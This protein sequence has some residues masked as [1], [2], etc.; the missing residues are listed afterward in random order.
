MSSPTYPIVGIPIQ[1]GQPLPLRQEITA[2]QND[3]DNRYQ[4]SLFLR[5]LTNFKA[6]AVED[7][8]GY[9]QIAVFQQLL[10]ENMLE[11]ISKWP[12]NDR[13][14]ETWRAAASQFRLPYWDWAQKQVYTGDYGLPQICT[15][16]TWNIVKPG[17][18]GA[19]EPFDNPLTGFINPKKDSLGQSVPMGDK[20]MGPNAIGDDQDNSTEPPTKLPNATG[21]SYFTS[22]QK[23]ET[24]VGFTGLGL[25]HMSDVPVAAFDPIFWLHH[26]NIDRLCAMWQA[27]NWDKWF[28]SP[29]GKDPKPSQS[30]PPFHYNTQ[31]GS[32]TSDRGRDWRLSNYQYDDLKDMPPGKPTPVFQ[33]SLSQHI[34]NLY[35]STSSI[36]AGT[37]YTLEND[38]FN[39]YIINVVYDRYALKGRAYS[40]LFYIGEPTRDFSLSKSDPNFVGAIFTF[41]APLISADGE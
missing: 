32:W 37:G 40:I 5:A 22:K 12:I 14:K 28:D 4:V 3:D 13:E 8:L 26:C 16:D 39:D 34:N 25:G 6:K 11:L 21:G 1:H 15:Q 30:L 38:T 24:P 10:Y 41:S 20:S 2:W 35:A 18:N 23:S 9:F 7:P 31:S 36:V 33:A 29:Q 17:A 19:K 27:L